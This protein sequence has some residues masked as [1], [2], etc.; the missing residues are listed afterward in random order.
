MALIVKL[1]GAAEINGAGTTALYTVPSSVSGAILNNVRL[2]NANSPPGSTTVDLYFKPN[3]GNQV[4]ILDRD[5][6]IQNG[7]HVVV[8]PE[9]TMAALDRIELTTV[10]GAKI[11]YV[12]SG[13]E[14]Q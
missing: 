10:A 12:V 7:N 5:L 2:V 8:T 9:L 13:A 1:L 4:R 3:T 6:P 14:K 11:H